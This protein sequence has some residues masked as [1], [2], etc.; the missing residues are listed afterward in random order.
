MVNLNEK[1]L[2]NSPIEEFRII[3]QPEF[4]KIQVNNVGSFTFVPAPNTCEEKDQFTYLIRTAAGFDTVTVSVE[5]LCESLTIL[6]GFSPSGDGEVDTFTIL[7]I[8]NFPNNSLIVFNKW[9][10]EVYAKKGYSNEWKGE[11]SDGDSLASEDSLYYY[12]FNNGEGDSYSG[13]V[14]I[15]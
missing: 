7:G 12:V 2:S 1:Q 8:Q 5:I 3:S 14:Q 6:N 15:M 11:T 13:Y 4:G 9:G 10:E